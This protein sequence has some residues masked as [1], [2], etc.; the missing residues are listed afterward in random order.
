MLRNT[1]LYPIDDS[2]ERGARYL[3]VAALPEAQGGGVAAI[4]RVL[5]ARGRPPFAPYVEIFNT[6]HPLGDGYAYE[7]QN[8]EAKRRTRDFL[9]VR[10]PK[11]LGY[12]E[13]VLELNDSRGP[14]LVGARLS[15]ADL[16]M[17]P[18]SARVSD[19]PSCQPAAGRFVVFRLR[20][21][22]DRS[23]SRPSAEVLYATRSNVLRTS[24]DQE[25]L[26]GWS[27]LS[28]SNTLAPSPMALSMA[29]PISTCPREYSSSCG[30][31]PDWK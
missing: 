13:R 5:E 29:K 2:L 25:L 16:S 1:V 4:L 30:S 31:N 21:L 15:Y 6:H 26:Y 17:A 9:A 28:R 22:L 10:L 27:P 12:F 8:A 20:T 11:F 24:F 19:T 23:L 7:E 3:D 18:V 14:W